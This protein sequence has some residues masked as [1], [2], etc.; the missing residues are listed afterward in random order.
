MPN[1]VPFYTF[2]SSEQSPLSS[3]YRKYTPSLSLSPP[4][5][6]LSPYYYFLLSIYSLLFLFPPTPGIIVVQSSNVYGFTKGTFMSAD[7][8][9]EFG[10]VE[11]Q[12]LNGNVTESENR[13]GQYTHQLAHKQ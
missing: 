4:R 7:V 3:Q 9:T 10:T 5:L 1:R 6:S 2:L 12:L 13:G 11:S 8:F